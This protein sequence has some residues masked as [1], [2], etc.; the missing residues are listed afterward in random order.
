MKRH[1]LAIIIALAM[2]SNASISTFNIAQ[3][4]K[5]KVVNMMKKFLESTNDLYYNEE[6]DCNDH[7]EHCWNGYH[8]KPN[9]TFTLR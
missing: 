5:I 3:S 8:A 9:T 6:I 7:V 1:V 4:K 2:P